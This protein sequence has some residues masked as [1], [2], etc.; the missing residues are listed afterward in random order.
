[1][2]LTKV[3]EKIE[4]HILSSIYFLRSPLFLD[5]VGKYFTSENVTDDK[6]VHAHYML[7]TYGY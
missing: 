3:V 6:T 5:N 2:F 7:D 4:T 1:M